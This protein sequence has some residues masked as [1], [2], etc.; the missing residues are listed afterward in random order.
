MGSF[1]STSKN[2]MSPRREL[3]FYLCSGLALLILLNF[4]SQRV[5][6]PP[7]DAQQTLAALRRDAD[8]VEAI[9]IGASV[10]RAID[11]ETLDLHGRHAWLPRSDI[12][13]A[14]AI[15]S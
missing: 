7:D 12:Y 8:A 13:E 9:T 1:I 2:V 6:P 5:F 3:V 14:I 15:A 10:N 11:F 4:L